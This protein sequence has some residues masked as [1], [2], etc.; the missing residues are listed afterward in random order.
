MTETNGATKTFFE[1]S[2]YLF[3]ANSTFVE[4]MYDLFNRDP[5]LVSE[6]WRKY[7]ESVKDE[8]KIFSTPSWETYQNTIIGIQTQEPAKPSTQKAP[9]QRSSSNFD[10][11]VDTIREK[12]HQVSKLD[13]LEL[14]AVNDTL[15][16]DTSSLTPDELKKVEEL[17]QI[18]C[19][20]AGYE[21]SYIEKAQKNWLIER[22]E[23]FSPQK[24]FTQEDIKERLNTLLKIES[25]E[26]FLQSRF[27][28]AKRFSIEGGENS[29][30]AARKVIRT[31]ASLGVEEI[32]IGMPHRGR[33]SVLTKL[34]NKPY[35]A[36]LAEFQGSL[37][38]PEDLDVSG[39]VKYHLG[40]STTVEINNK[41]VHIS[42]TPNPSH[43]ESVDP[44]VAGRVRAKQDLYKDRARKK[45]MGVLLHGDASF[46]GQGV[47]FESLM[48]SD[49]DGYNCGGIVHI[50]VNNQVGFT[51]NISE[52]R[53]TRY[54]TEV[55]KCI[56][57]P[58]FH[59]NGNDAAQV[60]KVAKIAAEFRDKFQKDVVI[61]IVCYR[62]HGHN[63][64]DEPRFTQPE[65][66]Q[67]IDK[68]QTPGRIYA[69]QI[70][71]TGLIPTTYYDE[72]RNAFKAEMEIHL[73]DS[74]RHKSDKADWFEGNWT[75][76]NMYVRGKT[77]EEATGV[78]S[79]LLK[80]LGIKINT[81][82]GNIH[83]HKIVERVYQIRKTNIESGKGLDWATAEALAFGSLALEGI[84]VRLSGQDCGR[85]TFSHRHSVIVDQE[86]G[87]HYAP[88]SN[89][90]KTQSEFEV[91][92]SLL[93]EFGVMGF[94][95]GYS[96]AF[97]NSLVMWEGQFGDFAN[98]A[99]VIIDQYISSAE[100][101]WLRQSGL[102]LLLPHGY[103][104]QGPEHSSARLERYLQ[105]CAQDNIQVAN[106]STPANYFHILRRQ[107]KRDYRKPLIL[108]TPKY[109]LRHKL[110][111]SDF[112][113]L[114]DNT[115]FIP[116]ISD[117]LVKDPR[118]IV[119]CSGKIYY[120]LFEEREKSKKMDVALIRIEQ[121]YP[122]PE[123][124][125]IN[126]LKQY[127]MDTMVFAQE[128][129][130]NMGAWYFIRPLLEGVME[131]LS[132]KGDLIC[133]SRAPS[134]STAAGYS[135]MHATE[136]QLLVADILK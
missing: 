118:K 114:V 21:F 44:V 90:A 87:E 135:K 46:A 75:G 32:V 9:T 91:I 132:M 78:K 71:K 77:K 26:Q 54:P 14:E 19:T 2:D 55:A 65:M 125:L 76:F 10:K 30:L 33:I 121:Y 103:E 126:I 119:L 11:I 73:K 136:Q 63:E 105:L 52:A 127:K 18:Y 128:E 29:I 80:E 109:L 113:D 112:S 48:M 108:I 61:D 23:S 50:V 83:A 37:A 130:Q 31:A 5:N 39:D 116:V 56:Q 106:C 3:S 47:V 51:A 104:G 28:G 115:S 122:F 49:L 6:E 57:A 110:A 66:Y 129:P 111:V 7:F 41:K 27:P 8:A 53:K 12:G 131:K 15:P 38:H 133:A 85:G 74:E 58:V 70:E 34:M 24:E 42:L 94:E 123:E 1:K 120:D 16:L 98:G 68:L 97:P 20:S 99:Q 134:A 40:M 84:R 89:I 107:V 64:I 82:P 43:L 102:V 101:K 117:P 100:Y 36:M 92:N 4:E 67:K 72:F 81:I 86:T 88:L 25:F 69:T 124:E 17:K 22:V 93:S 62:L 96:T 45:V 59:V 13:P 95:Y 35:P 79:V 60:S